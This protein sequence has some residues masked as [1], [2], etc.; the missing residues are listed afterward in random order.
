MGTGYLVRGSADV[1]QLDGLAAEKGHLEAEELVVGKAPSSLLGRG[2]GLRKVDLADSTRE[3]HEPVARGERG[4]QPVCHVPHVG[5]GA[6][7]NAAHPGGGDT[8]PHRMHGQNAP[9]GRGAGVRIENLVEGRPHPLEAV[10]KLDLARERH[11]VAAL[12]LLGQPGLP[13]EARREHTR[14]V[15]HVELDHR[16]AR[17]RPLEL[18]LVDGA[19]HRDLAAHVCMA[20]GNHVGVV[21]VAVRD[22]QEEVAHAM[23]AQALQC[24]KPRGR[25]PRRDVA[26]ARHAVCEGERPVDASRSGPDARGS[27]HGRL[28]RNTH[29]PLLDGEDDGIEGL[30]AAVGVDLERGLGLRDG[31]EDLLEGGIVE[32]C[33]SKDGEGVALLGLLHAADELDGDVL[34]RG[35]HHGD[36]TVLYA[37]DVTGMDG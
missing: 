34:H 22:M 6:R 5:K 13:E 27:A 29:E 8:L 9:V 4:R 24:V 37:H 25:P 19:H 35:T 18:H 7:D 3:R 33:A 30:L 14:L 11:L 10:G 32:V 15:E 26:Q 16:E 36:D 17:P 28:L 12:D 21:N 20:Y 31:V 2:K 1:A 23:D